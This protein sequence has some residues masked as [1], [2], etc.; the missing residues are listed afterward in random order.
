VRAWIAN[1][2]DEWY[3]FLLGRP[4]LDDV[5]GRQIQ[6]PGSGDAHPDRLLLD[7][8]NHHVFRG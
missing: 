7:W 8:H 5:T 4:D 3:R 6:L 1:T 2:D